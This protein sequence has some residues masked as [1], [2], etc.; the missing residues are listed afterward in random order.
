M[1]VQWD[2]PLPDSLAWLGFNGKWGATNDK[3]GS[4]FGP[5]MKPEWQKGDPGNPDM[6]P[7]VQLHP[8]QQ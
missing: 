2:D 4:P 3:Y 7:A 8:Q 6:S 5:A 1:Q